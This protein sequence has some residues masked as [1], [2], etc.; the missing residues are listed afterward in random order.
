MVIT[1]GIIFFVDSIILGSRKHIVTNKR[2]IAKIRKKRKAI[3]DCFMTSSVSFAERQA[4]IMQSEAKKATKDITMLYLMNIAKMLFPLITLPYLTRVLTVECYAVVAYVKAV[5]H[6]VQIAL[7][8]GFTLS[9]TKDIVNAN[10]NKKEIGKI[11]GAV[12]E[13]KGLLSGIAGVVLFVM[14]LFIPL[15]HENPLYT[16]L[17]FINIVITEML[18]DFLFRG[19]NRMEVITLR[20]VVSKLISTL[21]TFAFIKSDSDILLIP[22]LDIL[23]TLVALFLVLAEIRKIG[24]KIEKAP[25]YEAI[26]KLKESAIYFASDMATT[27]F[28][29]LNTLLIG[30]FAEKADVSYWSLCMQ[31]VAAVQSMYTP[32][33]NGIYP[34][35]VRTKNFKFIKRVLLIF[36][37]IVAA[38]CVF[39]YS[40]ANFIVMLVGG[41]QYEPAV[42]VF[43][44]LIPVLFFSFPGILFG[45]PALAPIDRQKETT[46]TTIFTAIAQVAGLSALIL[47]EKFTLIN[48]AILRG[49]TELLMLL[50]R[51]GF[52]YRFRHEF[53]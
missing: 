51:A 31:L 49:G 6:Y 10:G 46:F 47:L 30:I 52:C 34:S 13:A 43:R 36:M 48:I 3:G 41:S 32:I 35:M 40:F 27:A 19:I 38:G 33:A 28:G 24:I 42:G 9:A 2:S 22:I 26:K 4:I 14:F 7:I 39:C 50:L 18:A 11:T 12:L 29:A 20:F 16:L 8:F 25:I 23:G 37:P 44:A 5:M 45:W 17:A 53:N 21:L 15:L 1:A